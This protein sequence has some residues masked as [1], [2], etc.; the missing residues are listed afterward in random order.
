MPQIFYSFDDRLHA[1]LENAPIKFDGNFH[2]V[3]DRF[4]DTSD[5]SFFLKH[6]SGNLINNSHFS[7]N[8]YIKSFFLSGDVTVIAD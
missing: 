7:D 1:F 2:C 6:S 5:I 4:S 3:F 8:I